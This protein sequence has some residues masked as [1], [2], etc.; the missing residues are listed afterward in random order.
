ML[1][2]DVVSGRLS[3]L[4]DGRLQRR[5]MVVAIGLHDGV[6][7][8]LADPTLLR[9]ALLNLLSYAL[10][11]LPDGATLH[12]AAHAVASNVHLTV[13]QGAAAP[14]PAAGPPPPSRREGVALAVAQ[15]LLS[16][17]N[18]RLLLDERAGA[19][20]AE[21]VLPTAQTP[22]I[23]IVDDNQALVELFQRYLAGHRLVVQWGPAGPTRWR[24]CDN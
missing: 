18:G 1:L 16:A 13:R 9:Q 14:V 22:T 11:T 23:L 7:P 8:V 21:I 19:W 5:C 20:A 17:Q 24:C 12:V 2:A 4:L 15:S 10:D 3:G 6:P